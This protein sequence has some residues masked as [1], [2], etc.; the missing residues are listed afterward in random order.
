MTRGGENLIV[1]LCVGLAKR[2]FY[3]RIKQ[4][5]QAEYFGSLSNSTAMKSPFPLISLMQLLLRVLS[6]SKRTFPSLSEF[7]VSF[8]SIK[9]SREVI[10]VAQPKGF[11]PQVEP[12]SPGLIQSMTILS[13]KRADTGINPPARALPKTTI[14]GLIPS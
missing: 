1:V 3:L 9:T 13:A 6:P 14:S 5:S 2:P 8:S 7:S 4:R 12:W 11:P 10:A